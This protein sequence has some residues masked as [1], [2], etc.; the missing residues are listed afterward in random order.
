MALPSQLPHIAPLHLGPIQV[1]I[2]PLNSEKLDVVLISLDKLLH[3]RADSNLKD[4][5]KCDSSDCRYF[6]FVFVPEKN[7]DIASFQLSL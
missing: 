7:S 5:S 2:K 1:R 6:D 4:L 3:T